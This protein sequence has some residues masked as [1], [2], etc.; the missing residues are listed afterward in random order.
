MTDDSRATYTLRANRSF[1]DRLKRAA[2]DAGHS[3][4]AEIIKRL[5][6]NLPADSKFEAFLREEAEE[7]WYLARGAKH[8][9]ERIT[10][11]L[12]RQKNSLAAGEQ[13]DGMLLGQL[14]VEHRSA[15]ERVAD[16]ERR[17]RRIKR[18]LGE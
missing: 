10:K 9:Y 2:D 14:I 8:D 17:L 1:L 12:E 11:D 5:E 13:V 15:A 18:V 16:Y 7:L 4:N 3:M 6:S